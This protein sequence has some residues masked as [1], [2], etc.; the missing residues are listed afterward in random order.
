[1]ANEVAPA[2]VG[3]IVPPQVGSEDELVRR[4]LGRF[5]S[6]NTRRAYEIDWRAF[7]RFTPVPLRAAPTSCATRHWCGC[8]TRR[9]FV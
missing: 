8:S 1:M 3:G 7:R 2:L 4:W 5:Q 9:A 6:P